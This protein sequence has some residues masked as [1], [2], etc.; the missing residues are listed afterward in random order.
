MKPKYELFIT[1][2]KYSFISTVLLNYSVKKLWKNKNYVIK[3]IIETSNQ[4]DVKQR[5]K[6]SHKIR[7][8]FMRLFSFNFKNFENELY[9]L[10]LSNIERISKKYSIKYLPFEEYKDLKSEKKKILIN[11]GG[12]KIFKKKF[13]SKFFLSI[14]YHNS[15]LPNFRGT[16]SNGYSL[17]YNKIYTYYSFHFLNSLIDKGFIFYKEKVKINTK[18]LFN[19]NYDILKAKKAGNNIVYVLKKGIQNKSKK[20]NITVGGNYYNLNYFRNFF[21]KIEN[22]RYDEIKKFIKVFDGFYYKNK[23]VT[24]IKKNKNGIKIKN[25][26][27]EFTRINYLPTNIYK[28][29]FFLKTNLF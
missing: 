24:D 19:L 26:K 3:N 6:I 14:N 23:F 21:I 28:I 8:L 16:H 22:F 12:S 29:I 9:I 2:N 20:K 27:I 10:K 4:K 11:F 15:E 1:V 7:L 17:F 5:A 18:N 25:S 13:I